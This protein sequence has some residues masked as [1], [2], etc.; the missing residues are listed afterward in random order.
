MRELLLKL[1]AIFEGKS[2]ADAARKAIEDVADKTK[3]VGEE[4]AQAS[5]KVEELLD[6][7]KAK[8]EKTTEALK[9]T[10]AA[11][12]KVGAE[13][14]AGGN[15]SLFDEMFPGMKD[16]VLNRTDKLSRTS[17]TPGVPD[18]GG[19]SSQTPPPLPG[20]EN[21]AGG[22]SGGKMF[23]ANLAADVAARGMVLA[24]GAA[25]EFAAQL[26]EGAGRAAE[27][28]RELEGMDEASRQA[29]L[30]GMGPLGAVIQENGPMLAEFARDVNEVRTKLDDMWTAAGARLVPA[31]SGMAD[32]LANLDLTKFGV[33]IGNTAGG[34]VSLATDA[35]SAARGL[36]GGAAGAADLVTKFNIATPATEALAWAF[37][38]LKEK[39]AG[40]PAT[41][42][43]TAQAAEQ[44]ARR[45]AAAQ[46]AVD[47]VKAQATESLKTEAEQIEALEARKAAA[48]E[49]ENAVLAAG[50]QGQIIALEKKAAA[51]KLSIGATR[52][53]AQLSRDLR[54]AEIEGRDADAESISQRLRFY[55]VLKKVKDEELAAALVKRDI[56][57]DAA[58]AAKD[59][60]AAAEKLDKQAKAE[61]D[62][63]TRDAQ[64]AAAKKEQLA[65]QIQLNEAIAAGNKEEAERVRWMQEY[66]RLQDQGFTEEDARQAANASSGAR[67]AKNETPVSMAASGPVSRDTAG[68][69]G[70]PSAPQQRS[71]FGPSGLDA[72]VDVTQPGRPRG[73]GDEVARKGSPGFGTEG[74][75]EAGPQTAARSGGSSDG[76]NADVTA[77]LQELKTAQAEEL[78]KIAEGIREASKDV[79]KTAAPVVSAVASLKQELAALE[80]RFN[81]LKAS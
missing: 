56:D 37:S 1:R 11:A 4:A 65:L 64:I 5:P 66:T 26:A 62:Q 67:M 23:A 70:R 18:A 15:K 7:T 20:V 10:A 14:G 69:A 33:D 68:L 54:Q 32:G 60:A 55:D 6:T 21:G 71:P 44:H 13:T 81:A 28:A 51:E 8:A 73:L 34:L 35:E 17:T 52:E 79:P 72:P 12:S 22:V 40:I 42:E 30:A 46:A 25:R 29:A 50:L 16:D 2:E 19:G 9:E 43:Q 36:T 58:K 41:M 3:K 27:M 78:K 77:A 48:I 53:Q 39:G 59:A 45:V 31:L 76:G 57:L 38:L 61:E 49:N 47:A 63:K 80:R 24:I 75:G 74:S